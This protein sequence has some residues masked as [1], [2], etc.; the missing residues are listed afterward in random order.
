MEKLCL[1]VSEIPTKS[2]ATRINAISFAKTFDDF[3]TFQTWAAVSMPIADRHSS[4][5]RTGL[6][7]IPL[8]LRLKISPFFFEIEFLSILL[9]ERLIKYLNVVGNLKKHSHTR[10]T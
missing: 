2:K 4:P 7:I 10:R 6:S 1:T 9:G 8:L 3:N 5:V